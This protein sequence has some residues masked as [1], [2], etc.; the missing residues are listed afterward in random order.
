MHR[1]RHVGRLSATKQ[2]SLLPAQFLSKGNRHLLE[3]FSNTI[4]VLFQSAIS[5]DTQ[6]EIIVAGL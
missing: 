1:L 4:L 3:Q 2:V 5:M 6:V